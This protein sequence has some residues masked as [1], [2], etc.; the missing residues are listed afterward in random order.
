MAS[1][2]LRNF[3]EE[4][5]PTAISQCNAHPQFGASSNSSGNAEDRLAQQTL[6]LQNVRLTGLSKF[7]GRGLDCRESV[8]DK[9]KP[10]R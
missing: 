8:C 6:H 1:A 5:M 2:P 9:E 10:R 4:G 3:G 7:C